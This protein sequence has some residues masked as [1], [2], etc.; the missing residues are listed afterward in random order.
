MSEIDLETTW[1]S[2][3]SSADRDGEV[4][5]WG[6]LTQSDVFAGCWR[7]N[8]LSDEREEF[9]VC[10]VYFCPSSE[11]HSAGDQELDIDTPSDVLHSHQLSQC[12]GF[13]FRS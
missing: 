9:T 1:Y 13:A 7:Q 3:K 11:V 4:D 10:E 2:V 6:I 8:N 12:A 5:Y